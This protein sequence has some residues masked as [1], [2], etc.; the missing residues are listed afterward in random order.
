MISKTVTCANIV[1]NPS[2]VIHPPDKEI[3]QQFVV[4][5]Q[6]MHVQAEIFLH[7]ILSLQK[8][9]IQENQLKMLFKHL[10][11]ANTASRSELY[12]ST[13]LPAW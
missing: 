3:S 4:T 8:Y 12:T 11:T 10:Q 2:F 7:F 1:P 5:P 13:A 9:F 6:A